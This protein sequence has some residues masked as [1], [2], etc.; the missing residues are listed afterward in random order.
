MFLS[1]AGVLTI[2][3]YKCNPFVDECEFCESDHKP[4]FV[5]ECREAKGGRGDS[6]TINAHPSCFIPFLKAEYPDWIWQEVQA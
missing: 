1:T 5:Y 3:S 6:F 2:R 4:L